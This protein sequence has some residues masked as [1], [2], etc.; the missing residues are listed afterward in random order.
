VVEFSSP[1]IGKEFDG[2][3]LRSTIIGASIASLYESLGCDVVRMNFL[4]DWGKHIGL[5]AVGWSRFGSEELFEKEPLRHLV[6]VYNKID[7]IFKPEQELAKKLRADGHGDS[8]IET[9]GISVEKD[10]FFKKMEDGDPDALTLWRRFREVC[11]ASYTDLYARLNISF[12][13]YSGESDVS[14][15]TMTEVESVLKEKGVYEESNE[16]W[17]ID[18]KKHGYK[19]LGT[20]I[21]RYRNGTTSY[22]L[23]DIAAVLERSRKYSFDK[24]IYVVSAKQ[25]GHF[26]QLSKSLEL[27]GYSDLANKLHHVS[28]GKTQGVPGKL[29][30]G[31]LLGDML[32]QCQTII[33]ELLEIDPEENK[34]FQGKDSKVLETLSA[35]AL[36]VQDLSIRRLGNFTFDIH[37]IAV[38]D[39]HTGLNLQQ[40][41]AKLSSKLKGTSIPR[42]EL[43]IADYT[44][45]GQEEYADIL[46]VLTQFPHVVKSSFKS[47][48]SSTILAYLFRLTD[49]LPYVWNDEEENG[50]GS[51]QNSA[52]LAFFESVRQVLENGM[53]MV[54]LM[55]IKL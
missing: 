55:P 19:G 29:E 34:E 5:L 39:G 50:G 23:R 14:Q 17:L 43:E 47:L 45:F 37:N 54:G 46:R 32:E 20:A 2:N 8:V 24:M 42:D 52:E 3:H 21:A 18:F 30:S 9:Q 53:T 40:W 48:E 15:S 49:L 31:I 41:F 28:F 26:Q 10:E 1:N 22:L 12:D 16:A 33:R 36:M 51:Q 7:E 4:G 6:D 13:D 11:I 35:T 25:D 44:M 27:M 38:T